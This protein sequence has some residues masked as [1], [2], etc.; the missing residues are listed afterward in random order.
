MSVDHVSRDF[1]STSTMTTDLTVSL[2]PHLHQAL[3]DLLSLLPQDLSSLIS[4]ELSLSEIHYSL[5]TQVSRWAR[6][7][8]GQARLRGAQLDPRNYD[9]MVSLL[10]GTRTAP[11]SKPPPDPPANLQ[12]AE[13]R[14]RRELSDRRAI[15]GILN[16]LLTIGCSGA[17]A[18]WAAD[19]SGWKDEWVSVVL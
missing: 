9:N 5:L 13:S 16:G 18:W 14:A 8:A 15:V 10:A 6:T 19:K 7:D 2:E 11:S 3:S 4:E 12:S 1:S 17:A